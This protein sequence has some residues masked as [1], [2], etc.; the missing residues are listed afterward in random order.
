MAEKFPFTA[1]FFVRSAI[2]RLN[3]SGRLL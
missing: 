1:I 3:F 2:F